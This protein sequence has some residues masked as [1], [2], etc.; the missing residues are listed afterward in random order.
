MS[1]RV[2]GIK[3]LTALAIKLEEES[4][5]SLTDQS[6]W[7][8]YLLIRRCAKEGA[9]DE[10]PEWTVEQEIEQ[11]CEAALDDPRDQLHDEYN[12]IGAIGKELDSGFDL[13]ILN[14][15]VL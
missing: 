10:D 9:V 1:S 12:A 11:Q 15:E 7:L 8:E 14:Q 6:F 5:L 3:I 13:P 4:G 2:Q